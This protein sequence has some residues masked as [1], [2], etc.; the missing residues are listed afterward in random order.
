MTK[1]IEDKLDSVLERFE[2]IMSRPVGVEVTG[3]G[4]A[5]VEKITPAL[6]TALTTGRG[7]LRED[8]VDTVNNTTLGLT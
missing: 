7:G 1:R 6:Q 2:E 4:A 8:I 5:L 3:D